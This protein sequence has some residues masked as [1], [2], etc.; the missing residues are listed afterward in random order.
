MDGT[1]AMRRGFGCRALAPLILGMAG[2]CGC[3]GFSG[4]TAA[5]FLRRIE[6]NPDPN[7]R[8][9][10]YAKLASPGCYDSE[11]QKGEA[12]RVLISKREQGREPMA[13]RA[14][15][16]RTLGELRAKGAREVLIKAVS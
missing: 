11:Q 2:L 12:A 8:Y 4:T 5:S 1:R 16:C 6:E 13:T 15:I 14:V 10:A 3:S 9:D 7:L